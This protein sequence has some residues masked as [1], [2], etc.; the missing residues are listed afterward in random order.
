MVRLHHIGACVLTVLLS[1]PAYVR[2]QPPSESLRK[3]LE[4]ESA[5]VKLIERL[6]KTVCAIFPAM[7]DDGKTPTGPQ[8]GGSGVI[9]DAEGFALTNYHVAGEADKLNVG[10]SDGKIYSAVVMG[11]DPTGDIAVIKIEG[12][13]FSFAELGDSDKLSVGDGALAM[14]NPFG[15]ATDF[16]PTVTSGIVSGMHRYLPGTMGGDLIYT[17]CIQVDAPINPGNSGGP[18]FDMSGRL[19]GINGRVSVRPGRGKVNTGV[20]FAIPINQIR[21]FLPDLRAGRRVHHAILGVELSE[22]SSDVTIRRISPDSAAEKAGLQIGDVIRRFQGHEIG[23]EVELINRIG[24]LPANK[25]ARLVVE[26]GGRQYDVEVTLGER[27]T[28]AE[29]VAARSP[30]PETPPPAHPDAVPAPSAAASPHEVFRRYAEAL[31]G[32]DAIENIR[33]TI[34]AGR[35]RRRFQGA[36]WVDGRFTHY[37]VGISR[38]RHEAAFALGGATV[39]TITGYDTTRGWDFANGRIADMTPE[40]LAAVKTQLDAYDQLTR[41]NGWREAQAKEAPP[42]TLDERK[43]FVIAT[44]DGRD[45]ERRWSFDAETGLLVREVYRDP[46]SGQTVDNRIGDY[47]RVGSVLMPFQVRRLLNNTEVELTQIET[48]EVNRGIKD[49]FLLDRPAATAKPKVY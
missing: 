47:R 13:P 15:L 20:G 33:D 2:A 6:E 7:P 37:D 34:S 11:R 19:V 1:V 48:V 21:E 25:R 28:G 35:T 27:P 44:R 38:L 3:V 9:I 10:L 29:T 24:V 23:S 42:E 49:D 22:D 43:V 14:G 36:A 32:Y 31:G 46:E 18:L 4:A 39:Q 40:R 12:G 45:T 26:R 17:D 16:V 41:R 8:G 5:R 30:S